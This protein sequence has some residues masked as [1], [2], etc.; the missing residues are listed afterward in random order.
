VRSNR[1]GRI[2]EG[3]P[4][5]R[6]STPGKCVCGKPYR[7][8]ESLPLRILSGGVAEWLKADASPAE[9]GSASGG[10]A[11][12]YIIYI[13]ESINTGRLYTG[14]TENIDVRLQNHNS[15]KVKSTKAYKPY[16][17]IHT[18]S[19]NDKTFARKRELFLKSGQ[20]RKW[21]K[22]NIDKWRDG[23][24][25]EGG[26]LESVYTGNGIGGS[27]PPPSANYQ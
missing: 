5:G 13:L 1:T 7:E 24:V 19:Y 22:E 3:C 26:R 16:R 10:K 20:G 17:I 14:Y 12:M 8:F 25:A 11:S 21:I 27:N 2:L 9:G 15:G 4:S 18:E 23:R 6:R